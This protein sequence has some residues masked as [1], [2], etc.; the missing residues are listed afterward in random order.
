[1]DSLS[2]KLGRI[3]LFVLGGFLLLGG[4]FF[5]ASGEF[6]FGAES[7]LGTVLEA[8]ST[9]PSVS[10]V[11]NTNSPSNTIVPGRSQV[12]AVFDVKQKN[13]K[14]F[15]VLS[16]IPVQVLLSDNAKALVI[17]D[18]VLNYQYCLPKGNIY[19]YG[20]KYG[21]AGTY[22]K[23][24]TVAPTSVN[25]ID[26][27][28]TVK[29]AQELP[30]YGDQ[31]SAVLTVTGSSYYMAPPKTF[32][33]PAR[34]QAKIVDGATFKT[35]KCRTVYYGYQN[36]YSYN[37]CTPAYPRPNISLA[38]GNILPVSRQY[39]YGYA[40]PTTPLILPPVRVTATTT[41]T[42]VDD[43]RLATP[44]STTPSGIITATGCTLPSV[45]SA[46]AL[47][48]SWSTTGV[49]SV[50]VQIIVP[51]TGEIPWLTAVAATENDHPVGATAPGQYTFKLFDH[52]SGK[53]LGSATAT[54]NPAPTSSGSANIWNA[55]K[56][57]FSR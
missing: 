7:L 19:A 20:Y 13:T 28:Y 6:A 54:L 36:K 32:K 35:N 53:L 48:A 21:Y 47:A 43:S 2:H 11:R 18:F 12:L 30:V 3:S 38:R 14:G 50:D 15:S 49:A 44:A 23:T 56:S 17:K 1:M 26:N 41:T 37:L 34:V 57:I 8:F 24:L 9:G 29:F 27:S 39:G 10:I 46:C 4:S 16:N 25:R 40:T 51:V 55:L 22:C 33:Y 5:M 52:A 42:T 31:T 45:G